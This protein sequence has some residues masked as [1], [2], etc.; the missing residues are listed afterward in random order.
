MIAFRINIEVDC[1]CLAFKISQ[2]VAQFPIA[3]HEISVKDDDCKAVSFDKNGFK[4][5]V[6]HLK[7]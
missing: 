3:R 6:L 5:R 4:G 1:I 7:D 2:A